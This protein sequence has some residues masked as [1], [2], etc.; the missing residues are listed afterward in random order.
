[1]PEDSLKTVVGATKRKNN[2]APICLDKFAAPLD[3]TIQEELKRLRAENA[4][5][6]TKKKLRRALPTLPAISKKD[7][8]NFMA[9]ADAVMSDKKASLPSSMLARKEA[10]DKADVS[11]QDVIMDNSNDGKSH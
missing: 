6:K 4:K 3:V 10:A 9:A 1:M 8:N 11:S 2:S 7:A 5:L